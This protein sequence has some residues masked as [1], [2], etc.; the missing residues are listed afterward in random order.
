LLLGAF[1]SD[2]WVLGLVL[3]LGWP[4]EDLVESCR[5]LDFVVLVIRW[6]DGCD[7]EDS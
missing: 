6:V 1:S 7:A 2:A 4:S 3:L 5:C